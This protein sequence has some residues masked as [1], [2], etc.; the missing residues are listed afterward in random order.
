[1][2]CGTVVSSAAV[3]D[4]ART[5]GRQVRRPRR[6]RRAGTRLSG[7]SSILRVSGEVGAQ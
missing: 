6:A 5:A 7:A 1:M 2:R 4:V 3:L